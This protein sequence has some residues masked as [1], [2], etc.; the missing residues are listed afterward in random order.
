M[1]SHYLNG[2]WVDDS[3]LLISPLDLSVLR[4][5]GAFDFLTATHGRPFMLQ[6]HLG[7]YERSVASLGLKLPI[8]RAELAAVIHEG[9]RRNDGLADVFIRVILTGGVSHDFITPGESSFMVLFHPAVRPQPEAYRNGV[10]VITYPH[11]RQWAEV[12]SLDYAAA[13][14]ALRDARLQGAKEAIYTDPD[15]GNLLEGTGSNIFLVRDKRLVTPQAD[16]LSGVMRGAVLELAKD[17]N[18]EVIFRPIVPQDIIDCEEVFLTSSVKRIL[19][20]RQIDA[21][22]LGA[23][24]GPVTK[25]LQEALAVLISQ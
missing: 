9:I 25:S 15:S 5:F 7:R 14:V 2:E 23:T 4:G 6:Q 3:Q 8:G 13:V 12:K 18:I 21:M 22:K 17:L 20:V 11:S 16:I 24:V 10:K 19:P 1:H